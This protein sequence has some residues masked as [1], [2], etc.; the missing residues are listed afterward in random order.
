MKKR[1]CLN[2]DWTPI[3][4]DYT[5]RVDASQCRVIGAVLPAFLDP[6]ESSGGSPTAKVTQQQCV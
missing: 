2:F 3:K 5:F 6:S 4:S 1:K